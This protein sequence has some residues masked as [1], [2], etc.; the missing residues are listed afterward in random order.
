MKSIFGY[1][2]NEDRDSPRLSRN[3]AKHEEWTEAIL[4]ADAEAVGP[5]SE[6]NRRP[7]MMFAAVAVLA[8]GIL[9]VRLFAL[10]VLAGD[11]NLALA[12]GNRIRERVARAPRGM[13]FD[14]NHQVLARNQA[15]FDVTVVPQL[16]PTDPAA[17]Q[18][19]YEKVGGLLGVSGAEVAEKAEVTCKTH[20]PNCLR[21]P[22]AQLVAAGVPREKSLLLDESSSSLPGF[23]LDV[24]PIREYK[25][26][27]LLSV[28]LGYTARVSPAEMK[29][30]ANYGPTD[31]AGKLGLEK[32]YEQELRGQNG[33]WPAGT[34]FRAITW[35]C[36]WTKGC[37]TRWPRQFQ[38]K[39]GWHML[40]GQRGWH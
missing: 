18:A 11:H 7:L 13:I 37:S 23:A 29:A 34:Q 4:P 6:T 24:N 8:L 36:R 21:T 17:R 40:R 12:N 38:S 1:L 14:R 32:Q 9:G 27:N 15:S 10:Q 25:D 28:F 16:L 19:E 22:V 31:L 20:Q 5:D 39:W 35:C 26:D 33:G 2:E 3:L 30:D